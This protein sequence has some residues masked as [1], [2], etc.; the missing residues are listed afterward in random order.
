MDSVVSDPMKRRSFLK[1][2]TV[3][4]TAAAAS[5]LPAPAISQG[6][7]E[8]RMV[9]SWPKGL[10]GLG[11]GAERLAERI[12][13]LSGGRITVKVYSA[14]EL[15]PPLGVFDAV[16]D[17]TAQ[18]GHDAAYY[19]LGK[20]EGCAFYTSFPWG[21]T[22]NEIEAWV[23]YGNGQ[24]LWDELYKPFGI[25]GF[26][27]GN[28][29]TQMLGWFSKEIRSVEDLKG[30]KFRAPGNQGKILQKLGATPVVLAGGEIF[31]ALQSGAIDGAEWVGPY[32][33]LSL[34]FY[35]VCKYYYSYGYHEP[36]AALQLTINEQAWQSLS[37]ELQAIV[38][39]SADVA[40]QDMLAEYN[41][42]SGPALRT[43]VQDHGVQVKAMPEEVLMASG[44]AANEVLNEVYESGTP[45]VRKIVEDFLRFRKDIM[46][47][48]RISEQ[49]FINARRLPFEFGL[50][51]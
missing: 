46:P 41:A 24:T 15:V 37:S 3:A 27:A 40:N 51:V 38:K 22:A 8:W 34:G 23:G 50:K 18:L 16:A 33:D 5:A 13:T 10:P 20:S 36:G 47:W 14:G 35:Q 30:L 28:T 48:T 45:I 1:T 19:H 25:R 31:P 7:K 6:L 9:T 29:G 17:G 49:A 2:A 21:F 42:R 4:G 12:T 43:L 44:R 26:L 39:A 11:T 32:N